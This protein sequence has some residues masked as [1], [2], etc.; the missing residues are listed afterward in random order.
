MD[1]RYSLASRKGE[2]ILEGKLLKKNN[3]YMKQERLFRLY[4]NGDLSYF[5]EK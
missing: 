5:K 2:P 1:T 4:P 3:W